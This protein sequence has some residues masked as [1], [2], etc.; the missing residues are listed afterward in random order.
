MMICWKLWNKMDNRKV[1][2]NGEY[3]PL[4]DAKISVLD[5]GFLFGDGVYEVIPCYQGHL[6]EFE[7]H[8]VRLE[9]SLAERE[10]HHRI[11]WSNGAS[12]YC[13]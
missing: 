13:P 8:I 11:H 3:L 1:Y 12:Y 5:R 9:Q 10:F 2:L 6:F 4:K 7:A